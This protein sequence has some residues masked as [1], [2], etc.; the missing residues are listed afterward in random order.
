[1]AKRYRGNN[2]LGQVRPE[3]EP[4]YSVWV[5]MAPPDV[6]LFIALMQGYIHLGFPVAFNPK[7]GIVL[8]HTTS[9]CW[10]DLVK[11]INSFPITVHFS[12]NDRNI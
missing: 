2:R 12:E 8:I 7:E 3:I 5:K 4:R 11:V 1:M 9:D 10:P 6:H